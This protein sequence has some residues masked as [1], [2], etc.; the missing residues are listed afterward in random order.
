M[1]MG[2]KVMVKKGLEAPIFLTT[3]PNQPGCY[4]KS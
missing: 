3:G 2:K 1:G 4:L